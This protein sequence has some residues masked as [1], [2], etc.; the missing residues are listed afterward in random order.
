MLQFATLLRASVGDGVAFQNFLKDC[1]SPPNFKL[2]VTLAS[3][4]AMGVM[5]AGLRNNS[6]RARA[7]IYSPTATDDACFDSA[8]K[9]D[10]VLLVVFAWSCMCVHDIVGGDL[11]CCRAGVQ[12]FQRSAEDGSTVVSLRATQ[13]TGCQEPDVD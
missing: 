12:H 5:P 7:T 11:P 9:P 1:G 4:A 8:R 6:V 10:A 3:M 2:A 13:L